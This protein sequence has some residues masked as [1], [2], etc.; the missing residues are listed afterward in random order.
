M[1]MGG[2]AG[3]MRVDRR[4]LM[5]SKPTRARHVTSVGGTE[6]VRGGRR[7]CRTTQSLDS[8]KPL[9]R[10]VGDM[11]KSVSIGNA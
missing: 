10:M 2:Q 9:G 6:R 3:E 8:W 1:T 7:R 4:S 5:V 11:S